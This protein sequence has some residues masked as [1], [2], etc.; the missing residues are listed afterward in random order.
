MQVL[1]QSAAIRQP[2]EDHEV[3][4]GS[5]CDTVNVGIADEE[6]RFKIKYLIQLID[7]PVSSK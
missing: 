4:I 2:F 1:L 7:H 3:F 5:F 6:R